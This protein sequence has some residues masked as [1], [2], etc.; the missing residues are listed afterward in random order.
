[1]RQRLAVW[2]DLIRLNW[3]ADRRAVVLIAM[4]APLD[5]IGITLVSVGQRHVIDS[6]ASNLLSGILAAALLGA[7]GH[8]IT[9]G[10]NRSSANLQFSQSERVDVLV[11]DALLREINRVPTLEHLERSDYLDRVATLSRGTRSL[12]GACWSLLSVVTAVVQLGLST[13]LL[14]DVHPMLALLVLFAV[15]PLWTATQVQKPVRRARA[16]TAES[17]RQEAMLH[18]LCLEPGSAGELRLARASGA[19]DAAA[20]DLWRS[21]HRTLFLARLAATGWQF[22]GWAIYAT[23]Y[24]GALALG[25]W[26]VGRGRATIGDLALLVTLGSQLRAQVSGAAHEVTA[27]GETEQYVEHLAWLRQH[28]AAHNHEGGVAVPV[29]LNTGI[30]LENVEFSYPGSG[31]PALTGVNAVLEAGKTV[32]V[33]GAN[34]AG[35]TT[36]V[37]LLTGLYRPTAGT[38]TVDSQCLHELDG[39]AWRQHSTAVYQDFMEFHVSAQQAIGIGDIARMDDR[40]TVLAAVGRAGAEEV[41]ATLQAGLDT[42]LGHPNGADLS[43]GQWQKLALARGAMRP[44]ALLTVL[45]EPTAALDPLAEHELYQRYKDRAVQT[46]GGITVLVSHR[47]ATVRMADHIIVFDSGRV[48]EQGSHDDLMELEGIY[49]R[50]YRIQQDGYAP[51]ENS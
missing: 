9:N 45:D 46:G 32:A 23:G 25:A 5:A 36:L 26:L 35:K 29:W 14:F 17:Q 6:A 12:A 41:I 20:S 49:A 37:K 33:V 11:N 27:V 2:R 24:I 40:E 7:V 34:G 8:L 44:Q 47:F 42:Q 16:A 18:Q 39:T 30:K 22:S 51:Q 50:L 28:A 15:P 38:I 3:Q 43:R 48:M 1:M 21:S 31:Q 4:S 19:V 13:W 10:V